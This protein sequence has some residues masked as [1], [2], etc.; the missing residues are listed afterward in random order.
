MKRFL[1]LAAIAVLVLGSIAQADVPKLINF[2]GRL[3]TA[4]GDSVPSQNYSITFRIYNAS[5]GGSLLW[6][7]TQTVMVTKSL[8]SVV[9]GASGTPI[10]NS[11]F[12]DTSQW[13][14]I[15]VSSDPE[16]T[17]RQRLVSIGYSY[18]ALRTDTANLALNVSGGPFL[19]LAGGTMTG[20]ITNTGNP[21]ITMGKGNFGSG[22][23]NAGI[24]AFVAGE[25]NSSSGNFAVVS[26]GSNNN[27]GL[28]AVVGGG[29]ENNASGWLSTVSGGSANNASADFSSVIGGDGNQ[30]SGGHSTVGGGHC[31]R[32]RGSYS[33]VGG[34]GAGGLGDICNDSNSAL[35]LFSAITGGRSNIAKGD[36][37]FVGGGWDNTADS[38]AAC[39][40]G[41]LNN[42]A[43]GFG[44]VG[45]GSDNFANVAAT[46]GG[47][48]GNYANGGGAT[49]P[50]GYHNSATGYSSFAA[51]SWATAAHSGTFVWSDG[52][53]QNFTSSSDNQFL[54]R[55]IGGV[56]IGTNS[57]GAQLEVNGA[58]RLTDKYPL[59]FLGPEETIRYDNATFTGSRHGMVFT[60]NAGRAFVFGSSDGSTFSN[61]RMI[62]ESNGDVGIG[63]TGLPAAKL[64]V[65]GSAGNNTGV[66]SN[67]SDERLKTGIEPI[68][69]A[70]EAVER[71]RGVSFRWKDA[72]KDAE[73]GRV[74][75]L[76]AQDVEKAI[77]EWVKTDP[78]G[79]KR[80]EPIGIDALLIEAIKEQQKQ[81]E[82][83]RNEIAK[84]KEG[85]RQAKV[86]E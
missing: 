74:R 37:A 65:N 80:L 21:P 57:P 60:A 42:T 72:K 63:T 53:V 68:R 79:Y 41:G 56:G 10:P 32:A 17:P 71:L 86:D 52:T 58:V 61:P 4:T 76:I 45:G 13:L 14:A 54:I 33:F 5:S 47:G 25:N 28:L 34:G 29:M 40:A 70:L 51:G 16:M 69:D 77:P 59:Q 78:D 3:S 6:F 8:F 62:I 20:P 75:G 39:V 44:F 55:A 36:F 1:G 81:I 7:E 9:L 43:K 84:L 23:T 30:A 11:V 19:P 46:V 64:H 22:N 49:I 83:L 48:T 38:F 27:A 24:N 50:G 67:L 18:R 12:T 15:K 66:W 26:G 82:D 35:G 85:K 31:N 73:Y 2:Q